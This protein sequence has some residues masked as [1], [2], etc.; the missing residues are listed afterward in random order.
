MS[1]LRRRWPAWWIVG[2]VLA[3]GGGLRLAVDE[4]LL[5]RLTVRLPDSMLYVAYAE[6]L[7]AGKGF[8][9][10]TD[11]ALRP[12]GYPLFLAAC[13]R[14]AGGESERALLWAQA[15]LST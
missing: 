3:V 2:V 10:G 14:L 11:A 5:R 4:L 8:V 7:S 9:V 12:P 6:S 15:L 13:W 1:A